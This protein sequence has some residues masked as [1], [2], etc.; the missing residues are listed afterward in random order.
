MSHAP[1]PAANVTE[2]K[3][4]AASELTAENERLRAE[5]RAC[6]GHV[7]DAIDAE[8]RRI[9]RDLHDGTQG[10]LVSLAM[11][12]GLLEAKLP[13]EPDAA[14]P[15]VREACQTVAEALE[16]LRELSQGIYPAVLAERGLTSG[17]EE[18]C[19]RAALSAHLELSLDRRFSPEVEAAA[20]CVVSEALTNAAKHAHASA[21]SV[22]GLHAPRRLVLEIGDDGTGGTT[23]ATG[24]GLR[25]LIDR[26]QRLGGR[27]ALSSP[28]DEGTLIR[29]EIPVR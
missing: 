14:R 22:L 2:L 9:E 23:V 8:R 27:V 26:V 4:P 18:L 28:P 19:Q 21:V 17:L 7:E 16:E 29:A 5:L 15:I 13:S 11:S 12:L 20:Y 6:R 3:A 1:S 24:S 10:R 25:G